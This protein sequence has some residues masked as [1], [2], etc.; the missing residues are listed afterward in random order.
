[1][2]IGSIDDR[3]KSR[4]FRNMDGGETVSGSDF[5]GF[6]KHERCTRF[7]WR[8]RARGCGVGS[9]G[10]VCWHKSRTSPPLSRYPVRWGRQWRRGSLS[11]ESELSSW[12]KRDEGGMGGWEE[13][14]GG[15]KK[16]NIKRLSDAADSTEVG[17]C[18]F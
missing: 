5:W 18:R 10:E 2:R 9:A 13:T 14:M 16:F 7:D 11:L 3:S 8:C 17:G 1:M 4:E 6:E 15:G 12:M